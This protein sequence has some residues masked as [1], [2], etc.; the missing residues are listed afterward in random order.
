[1]LGPGTNNI[2]LSFF[3]GIILSK[4]HTATLKFESICLVVS[5]LE[6]SKPKMLPGLT[7]RALDPFSLTVSYVAAFAQK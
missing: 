4:K 2:L 7:S 3:P 6:Q 1:M 5:S